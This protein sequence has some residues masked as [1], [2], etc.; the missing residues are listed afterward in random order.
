MDFTW[1]LSMMGYGERW[2]QGRR[3]LHAHVHVGT[4]PEYDPMQL[5]RAHV[6]ARQLMKTPDHLQE[7]ARESFGG[8]VM[9]LV[10]GIDI[11]DK[12]DPYVYAAESV[13]HSLDD[14]AIPGK[15]LV[16]L[17]PWSECCYLANP[18]ERA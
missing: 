15:F 3:L 4:M 12:D 6:F 11:K 18:P 2:R 9:K 16:D 17:L 14:A 10:Y 13:L 5:Q 8:T 7:R 1:L